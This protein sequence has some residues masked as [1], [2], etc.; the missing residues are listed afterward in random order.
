MQLDEYARALESP[1][2]LG[3]VNPEITLLQGPVV[4]RKGRQALALDGGR[5]VLSNRPS[6]GIRV[7]ASGE[8]SDPDVMKR[9]IERWGAQE[10]VFQNERARGEL[11]E[12]T[13]QVGGDFRKL[14]HA[15]TAS[16]ELR[17]MQVGRARRL[18]AVLFHLP[19]FPDFHGFPITDGS[20]GWTGR[21]ELRSG[22]WRVLLDA[23]RRLSK[24]TSEL[25]NHGGVAVTHVGR[26]DKDGALFSPGEAQEML[27]ALHWFLS[28]VRGAWTSPAVLIGETTRRQ[29]TWQ[30]L[31]AGRTDAWS[32]GFRWCDWTAW[33]SAQEAYKGYMSLWSQSEWQQGL[34]VAIGLYMS[35]NKPN[36]I[37]TAII[38]A[39]TGL[40]LLGWLCFV[41]TR[42]IPAS[43]WRGTTYPAHRK[44]R[45]L[46]AL[47]NVDPGIPS[48]LT[49]LPALNRQWNDGPAVVSGVRN[50]LVHPRHANGR[51]GWPAK[52]LVET[53][54][55]ATYYLELVLL[56][57]LGVKGGIRNRLAENHWTG[58]TVKP[59]W[60]LP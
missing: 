46:L 40:E 30:L 21:T 23:R 3:W 38:A 34:P 60:A 44:I 19:N 51:I 43:H 31:T 10:I 9:A 49:S 59:P 8:S 26:L 39:Q 36:P 55:L 47:A 6:W 4:L 24:L 33:E 5:V 56:Q 41:E 58:S 53:W 45:Q 7:E 15:V 22:T 12:E 17:E 28:F 18:K 54:L 2:D 11:Y 1:F 48:R 13:V 50:R 14:P 35:A 25:R 29:A 16:G 37:E 42:K 20:V 57:V 32:D 52:V 27:G